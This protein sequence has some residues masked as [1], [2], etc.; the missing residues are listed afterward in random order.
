[1]HRAGMRTQYRDTIW[2][3][4]V[5]LVYMCFTEVLLSLHT[6]SYGNNT[7]LPL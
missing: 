5:S 1:M 7:G 2:F 4:I 3:Y 6:G